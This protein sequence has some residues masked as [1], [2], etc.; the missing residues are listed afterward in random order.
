MKAKNSDLQKS[1]LCLTGIISKKEGKLSSIFTNHF[2]FYPKEYF[3]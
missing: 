2:Y 1:S 3:D